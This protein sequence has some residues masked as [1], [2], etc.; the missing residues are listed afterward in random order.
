MYIRIAGTEYDVSNF[1]HP[2]G[3]K[4]LT[5]GASFE[6]ATIVFQATHR[7]T[8]NVLNALQLLPR[9]REYPN[10]L[11][12]PWQLPL[13][14]E[15]AQAL[16]LANPSEVITLNDLWIV[17]CVVMYAMAYPLIWSGYVVGAI[18][19]ILAITVT[20]FTLYSMLERGLLRL[21][22]DMTFSPISPL[23]RFLIRVHMTG[24]SEWDLLCKEEHRTVS[25]ELRQN[26][27]Y[28]LTEFGILVIGPAWCHGDLVRA[29]CLYILIR[30]GAIG[31]ISW[32]ELL[33]A[34]PPLRRTSSY[35]MSQNLSSSDWVLCQITKHTNW[36]GLMTS[37][38]LGGINYSIERH[39]F[40][41]VHPA[42]YRHLSPAIK[43]VCRENGLPYVHRV[44]F[45]E[46]SRIVLKEL[47]M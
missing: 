3:R 29:I 10:P 4:W 36:G 14:M 5:E 13:Y 35:G 44:S 33:G 20:R 47:F 2:G 22:N 16:D 17:M 30:L 31:V 38:L 27:F 21:A 37:G 40:P 19:A 34:T 7:P 41:G 39:L 15:M 18:M 25:V 43:R 11:N 32:F 23:L 45:W 12:T 26:L 9:I 46:A 24:L 1:R 8:H 6:D 42:H 28:L